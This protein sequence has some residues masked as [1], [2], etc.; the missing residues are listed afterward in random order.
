MLSI[1]QDQKIRFMED[2]AK[3]LPRTEQN[4]IILRGHGQLTN[5]EKHFH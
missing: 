2:H 3:L 5:L 1:T 4:Q